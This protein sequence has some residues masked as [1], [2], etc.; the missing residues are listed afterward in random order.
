MPVVAMKTVR[1]VERAIS[2]LYCVA[3]SMTPMGLT[4]ISRSVRLDKATTLRLITTLEREGLIR[5]EERS[6]EYTLGPGI[7]RL[8]HSSHADIRRI[9]LPHMET[10]VRASG[11]A[12]CLNVRRGFERVVVEAVE[13]HH[14]LCLVPRIGMAV[15]I[16]V[17][18]AGKCLLAHLDEDEVER[19][20]EVT[21][22]R[23]VTKDSITDPHVLKR[24]LRQVRR[25]GYATSRGETHV[26]GA[27][28]GAPVFDRQNRIVGAID[29]RGPALRLDAERVKQL[30]PLVVA[31]A[32]AITDD[33][34]AVGIIAR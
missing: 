25:K 24:Q 3:A 7:G 19:I 18:A 29:L 5:Q 4:E 32:K 23:P 17:G 16:H 31:C 27:A 26:G 15:P 14:E 10:L 1:S 21:G 11:E 8:I 33:L 9:C 12:V 30:A 13:A 2:I 22:L 34:Q 20:I 6:R 28:I